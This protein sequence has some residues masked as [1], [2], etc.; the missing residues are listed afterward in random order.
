[1][2]VRRENRTTAI[3]EE[4]PPT[5]PGIGSEVSE[6]H[7]CIE[8]G[9]PF[10]NP[11]G[12]AGHQRLAHSASTLD[13]L[14]QR[15]DATREREEEVARRQLELDETGPAALGMKKCNRC[16]S[17]FESIENLRRHNRSIHPIEDAVASEVNRSRER[18]SNVWAE[19]AR[20]QEAN[21][22]KSTDWVV[23]Q[24]LLP[25]DKKILRALLARSAAFHFSEGE[26]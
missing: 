2:S 8:C 26:G 6:K 4:T 11:Q 14:E 17:W 19:A 22:N 18:V 24:F 15:E 23:A 13:E 3:G 25:T 5:Q 7:T 21:P 10:R 1:M 12:L 16:E 9:E 20:K